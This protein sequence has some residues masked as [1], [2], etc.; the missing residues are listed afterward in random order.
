MKRGEWLPFSYSSPEPWRRESYLAPPAP[1]SKVFSVSYKTFVKR[2]VWNLKTTLMVIADVEP[3][4]ACP[5]PGS[6]AAVA[7]FLVLRKVRGYVLC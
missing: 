5:G 4:R 1:A 2:Q 6:P 3:E 7:S